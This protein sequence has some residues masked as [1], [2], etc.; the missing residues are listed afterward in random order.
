MSPTAIGSMPASGSSSRMK[1][2][3]EASA[4]AIST[5]RRSPPDSASA[6]ARRRWRDREFGEQRVDRRL[7]RLGL[8]LGHFE[9][10][11]EVL[12]DGQ[13]AEDRRLLRQIA[14]AEPG[15]AIHRQIGDVLAV[16][17]DGADIGPDQAGDDVEAGGLAGAV[18]AEQPDRLAALHRDVDRAQHRPPP[19]ALA[20]IEGGEAAIV[21]DEPRRRASRR[22][23]RSVAGS[24]A[25]ACVRR[26]AADVRP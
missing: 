14:D 23:W 13:A 9:H 2:G 6:G 17:R 21:G 3:C 22:R 10:G 20:E 26:A 7:A 5:R 12:L 4:R 18:G 19:E 11:A 1:C 16:E 25:P 8:G 24:A 15:A